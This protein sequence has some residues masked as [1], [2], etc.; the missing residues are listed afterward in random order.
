MWCIRRLIKQ[1]S[2]NPFENVHLYKIDGAENCRQHIREIREEKIPDWN[3]AEMHINLLEKSS[4]MKVNA[5]ER[6]KRS[7][8][9]GIELGRLYIR[10]WQD[11]TQTRFFARFSHSIVQGDGL[12]L[13]KRGL[14]RM[15]EFWR[16]DRNE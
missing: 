5:L 6:I 9:P 13:A 2:W 12:L 14:S 10:S 15:L 4:E 11:G 16:S 8:R 1:Q 7:F 3:R